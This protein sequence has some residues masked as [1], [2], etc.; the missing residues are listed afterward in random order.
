MVTGG[1]QRLQVYGGLV[2]CRFTAQS[3][4]PSPSSMTTAW[5]HRV[6]TRDVRTGRE[7]WRPER[8]GVQSLESRMKG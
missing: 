5:D 4:T 2:W 6:T 7:W 3:T 8:G 1:R